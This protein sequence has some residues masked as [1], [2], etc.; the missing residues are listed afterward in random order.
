M[1]IRKEFL[2]V[3]KYSRSGTLLEAVRGVAI[4]W[5]AN[6]RSTA[7]GNRNYFE[8]LQ[9]QKADDRSACYASAHYI[10]GL[11]G[12]VI[13]CLPENERAY[14]VGADKYTPLARARLGTYPNN[15]TIGIELCHLDWTGIFSKATLESA[16]VLTTSILERYNLAVSDIYRHYDITGKECPRYFVQNEAKW[17]EFL[18]GL[19]V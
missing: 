11:E 15:C 19:S 2:T 5:V 7:L 6:P 14:H 1:E 17:R 10:I 12:E 18:D 3:N 16:R 4:H 9:R 13:Q 8:N